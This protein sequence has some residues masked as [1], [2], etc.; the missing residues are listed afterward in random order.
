MTADDILT[1][2]ANAPHLSQAALDEAF[3]SLSKTP[4]AE[5]RRAWEAAGFS[6]RTYWAGGWYAKICYR[7]EVAERVALGLE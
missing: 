4:R 5:L 7:R 1:L 2:W 3:H 6:L